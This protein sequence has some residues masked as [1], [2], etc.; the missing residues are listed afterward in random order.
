MSTGSEEDEEGVEE[1]GVF[2]KVS[3]L[4]ITMEKK[5]KKPVEKLSPALPWGWFPAKGWR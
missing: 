3:I 1:G 2:Y 5:K 4:N